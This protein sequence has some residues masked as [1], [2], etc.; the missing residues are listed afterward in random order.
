[1]PKFFPHIFLSNYEKNEWKNIEK[2]MKYTKMKLKI[3]ISNRISYININI[4]QG[5]QIKFIIHN[6][7]LGSV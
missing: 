7:I 3:L 6:K 5:L 1:M 4:P 2:Q